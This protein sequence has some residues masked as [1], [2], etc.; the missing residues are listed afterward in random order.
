MIKIA[1]I[2]IISLKRILFFGLLVALFSAE[3][4]SYSQ[5]PGRF[6]RGFEKVEY[7]LTDSNADFYV[8][9][10][11][12]DAWSGKLSD[13]NSSQTDGPFKTIDRAQVAVRELKQQLFKPKKAAIDKRFKGTPHP[14][15][16][17]RDILV[18]LRDGVYYPSNT[19][20]FTSE[21][22]G[23]RVETDLPTGAFEYHELKDCFVTYAAYPGENAVI[24]GGSK[25]TGWEKSKNGK[26]TTYLDAEEV[27]DLYVN[28]KR[29]TLAR[30]PNSGYFLTDGQPLEPEWFRFRGKDIQP[31]RNLENGRI[32]MVVRWS[33]FYSSINKVDVKNRKA[34]LKSPEPDIMVV[35]PKYYLENIEAL[36][37]TTNEW[38]FNRSTHQLSFIPEKEVGNPNGAK[39]IVPKLSELVKV[40]GTRERPVYN[41]RFYNL[42]FQNTAIGGDAVISASYVKNC[43][44]LCNQIENFSQMGIHLG[45]GSF[46][47]LISKNVISDGKGDGIRVAGDPKPE[48]WEDFV[49]DN[50][51]SFNK[52]TNLRPAVRGIATYN[53]TRSKVLH[54][55]VSNTG[56]YGITLGSWPNI[57]ETSDGSHLAEFNHVSFTN[58]ERDDEGGMAVYGMSPG[59]VVRNNLIHDVHPAT[60]NENVGFFFQNMALGW[61][62]TNN[63]YFNLK[64]G[65]LK[66]CAAYPVDNV[67][68][69]NFV[70]ETPSVFSEEIISGDPELSFDQ[71]DVVNKN[72]AF[73]TGKDVLISARVF[74]RGSTGTSPVFLYVDGKVAQVQLFASVARNYRQ[75]SFVHKFA[76]PGDH[77][78][79][80][81]TTAE[82]LVHVEGE[83]CYFVY[84]NLRTNFTEIPEGDSLIVSVEVQN[85]RNE[86]VLQSLELVD[87]KQ[88][89]LSKQLSFDNMETKTVRFAFLPQCGTHLLNVGT[90]S[91]SS[92][93]VFPLK[94]INLENL[95]FQTYCSATAKP[96]EFDFSL[97]KNHYEISAAGTD[98]LH[99][100]DSYGTIFL[101]GAIESNFVAIVKLTTFSEGVSEWFRAG[102]FVRNDLAKS[103]SSVPGSLGSF[104]M[105]STPKRSGAEWDEF[106]NGCM[107]NSKSKNYAVDQPIPV[108]LKVVRRGN[109]FSGYYSFDAKNWTLS[110]DSG[111]LPGLNQKIDIGLAGGSNDQRMS[112]VIF[113]DF[114]LWVQP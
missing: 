12:N 17:G 103:N 37:D 13:P 81:G 65:E 11:G 23:E 27:N 71:P 42:K 46:N 66:Y 87:G 43:E 10:K 40:E 112:K 110:R 26:W 54:N 85:L 80:I 57:E 41:L 93:K 28:G 32:R 36:L 96:C 64:Q 74:N 88:T 20:L 9:P 30:T 53:A 63:I 25:I 56:S 83:P 91:S 109:K 95:E 18:L 33:S 72:K 78:V 44:W 70:I 108:W 16:T 79:S 77:R 101:K 31:W 98:F 7:S 105:F 89:I 59:S 114:Q 19:L 69:N 99:G 48:K 4:K 50:T 84:R 102:I 75:I 6:V 92:V 106:G 15:G 104:L 82:Q 51:I 111:D 58:M 47:N 68:K 100:E 73:E 1:A 39:I 94:K 62:V 60:T 86:K 45:A 52:V 29:M 113:D 35:P 14:L 8:S 3:K 97:A 24:S 34:Y 90:L 38:F 55:Y 21:D 67:Y 49:R 107:H 61:E 2:P 5:T 76:E 22:G